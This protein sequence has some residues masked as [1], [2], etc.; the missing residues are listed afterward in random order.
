[1]GTET[2]SSFN[3]L[4]TIGLSG[5]TPPEEL[6]PHL[7]QLAKPQTENSV[8]FF[9]SATEELILASCSWEL[10]YGVVPNMLEYFQKRQALRGDSDA[11]PVIAWVP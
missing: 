1:M 3:L 9:T 8:T 11:L 10:L 7:E 2:Q 6:W 5:S 4:M